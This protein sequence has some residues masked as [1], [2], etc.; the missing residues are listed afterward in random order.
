MWNTCLFPP[1]IYSMIYLCHYGLMDFDFIL[2]VIIQ[3]YIFCSNWSRF[4]HGELC[5]L[6]SVPLQYTPITGLWVCFLSS[7][8]GIAVSYFLALR[9]SRLTCVFPAPVRINHFSKDPLFSLVG[10]GIRN[11]DLGPVCAHCY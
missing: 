2:W 3:Y 9:C 7:E 5:R 11:Q 4:A 1:F 8:V 10:N 6:T